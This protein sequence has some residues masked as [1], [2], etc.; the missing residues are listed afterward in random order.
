MDFFYSFQM[1]LCNSHKPNKPYDTF[2][3]Y[4]MEINWK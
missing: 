1:L 2:N 4:F 3:R